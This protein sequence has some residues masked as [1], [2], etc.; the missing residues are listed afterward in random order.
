MQLEQDKNKRVMQTPE[1]IR[2]AWLDGEIGQSFEDNDPK[3]GRYSEYRCALDAISL[4]A[5]KHAEATNAPLSGGEG[6]FETLL[7]HG[8]SVVQNLPWA[9]QHY[10]QPEDE[11]KK[12][13]LWSHRIQPLYD[14]QSKKTPYLSRSDI[15]SA[16]GG[17]LALPYRAEHIDRL[18][19]DV[20]VAL[21]L[22][23]FCDEMI[24]EEVI[25]V[26]G[27]P[28]SPLKEAHPFVDYL[29]N[30][31]N[32]FLFW[33]GVGGIVFVLHQ[34]RLLSDGW[35][36]SGYITCVMLYLLGLALTTAFLPLAWHW[37][38]KKV[39]RVKFI[40]AEM[41]GCYS[42]L[43]S[44]GPVSARHLLERLR[45]AADKGVVWPAPLYAL[46]DDVMARTGRL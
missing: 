44:D 38:T 29:K 42:E 33:T 26:L 21:E 36:W 37:H 25:P 35:A 3:H 14:V 27:P 45:G 28:R 32:Y 6:S 9:V 31:F 16:V 22:Y 1:Q 43:A 20:L 5:L 12:L 15:E 39:K 4:A 13:K 24:N 10:Q 2:Q 11:K 23:Q 18:F 19:A 8:F 40:I 34:F 41:L 7:W 46:L 17:Y 30:M